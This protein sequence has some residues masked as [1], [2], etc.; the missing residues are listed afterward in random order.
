M[1][2]STALSDDLDPEDLREVIAAYARR[3]A[4]VITAAGGHVARYVGD[5]LLAYFG[6]PQA[7]EDDPERAIRAGLEL[8]S[9]VSRLELKLKEP[10][11]VRVGIATGVVV[12]SSGNGE[13]AP[14]EAGVVG[15][16]PNLAARLQ[17]IA[18]PGQV[19]VSQ[20]SWELTE[21]FFTGT[22]LGLIAVKGLARPVR[23]WRV[24]ETKAVTSRIRSAAWRKSH[25]TGWPHRGSR[26]A[27][28]PLERSRER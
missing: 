26:P 28:A 5:G 14:Q 7:H 24:L 16:T 12:V 3:S 19:V 17:A 1:V 6:Y 13:N 22:D 18:G 23:A 21:G 4:E 10:I 9:A 27:H 20:S 11:Q 2:G 8:V 25:G 15:V